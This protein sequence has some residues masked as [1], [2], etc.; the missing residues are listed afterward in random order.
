[1]TRLTRSYQEGP[2]DI[3]ALKPYWGKPAVRNFRG[4]H[5]DVGIIRSPVRAMVL[6]GILGSVAEDIFRHSPVPVLT[7][8]PSIHRHRGINQPH[9]ILAPCD[10][11]RRSHAA[12]EYAC[13]LAE[14]HNSQLT[15]LHVIERANEVRSLNP[16]QVKKE[17][18]E[19]LIE[20]VGWHDG[21]LA[22]RYRA[23][24]GNIL[25]SILRVDRKSTRLNSS[26]E[27]PSR[28]PS[29]A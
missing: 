25:A 3:P 27:I 9:H 23:E 28:M 17:I 26:H 6:P 18:Q 8:G 24:F 7:V 19:R 1:M 10:L 5:G 22:I 13:T 21:R 15:V 4:D 20:V 2:S 29:S 14:E 16:E 12:V 11:T